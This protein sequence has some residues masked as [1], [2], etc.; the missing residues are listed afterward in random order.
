MY[1]NSKYNLHRPLYPGCAGLM[2]P[3]GLNGLPSDVEL[4][5]WRTIVRLPTAALLCRPICQ[6]WGDIPHEGRAVIPNR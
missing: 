3:D 5:T 4:V 6:A 1:P 2:S